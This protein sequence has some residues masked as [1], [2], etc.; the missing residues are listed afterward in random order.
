M[1]LLTV[2]IFTGT[3][4]QTLTHSVFICHLP[5]DR[6]TA[7]KEVCVM[8]LWAQILPLPLIFWVNLAYYLANSV[9]VLSCKRE[10]I[11]VSIL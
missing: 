1:Y 5:C 8:T 3:Q 10:P 7:W 11:E 9:P 4:Q 6:L 2:R